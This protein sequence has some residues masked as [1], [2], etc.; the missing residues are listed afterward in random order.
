[1]A[2]KISEN[3]LLKILKSAP[4][5]K[6]E[7]RPMNIIAYRPYD[8]LVKNL[9]SVFQDKEDVNVQMDRRYG[10]RRTQKLPFSDERRQ[11]DR[12]KTKETLVE[13]IISI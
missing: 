7:T 12:R 6:Q 1:M 3:L 11:D 4:F 5:S 2:M 10:Q 13:V 9:Q 8:Y